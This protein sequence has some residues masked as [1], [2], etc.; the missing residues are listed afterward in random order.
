MN[1][2]KDI[3]NHL[4]DHWFKRFVKFL[5]PPKKS[6]ENIL[7]YIF[8][9]FLLTDSTGHPS[10]TV[11]ILLFVMILVA[12][13]TYTEVEMAKT[14]VNQTPV[15]FSENFMYLIISLSVVITGF[16]RARQNK[17]GSSEEGEARPGFVENVI[18]IV[19]GKMGN[20]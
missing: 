1:E 9:Q 8:R 17:H 20:R 4:K 10:I 13:V 2:E 19:K 6:T 18:E 5:L 16:Y 12:W 3:P 14:I 11:S 7:Q 15:G